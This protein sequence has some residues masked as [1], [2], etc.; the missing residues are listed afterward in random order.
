MIDQLDSLFPTLKV[1][2]LENNPE[3]FSTHL[4]LSSSL[5]RVTCGLSHLIIFRIL[6]Y[7]MLSFDLGP[8]VDK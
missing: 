8:Q 2:V 4:T 5:L 3:F 1:V 6:V 7:R